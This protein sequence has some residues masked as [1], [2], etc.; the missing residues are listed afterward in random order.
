MAI[1]PYNVSAL[2]LDDITLIADT[3]TELQSMLSIMHMKFHV[4]FEMISVR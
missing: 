2:L 3:P 1:S 4:I